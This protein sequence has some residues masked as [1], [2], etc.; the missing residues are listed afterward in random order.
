VKSPSIEHNA[1]LATRPDIENGL[2]ELG[3][4]R[5]DVVEVHSSL[6]SFGW[7]EGGAA[8]A[9]D[10]LM[11]V[12]GIYG[13]WLRTDPFGLYGVERETAGP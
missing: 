6:S 10:A 9:V 4:R 8:T 11:A 1:A 7:V 5:G 3:L 12:V 2:R 13:E